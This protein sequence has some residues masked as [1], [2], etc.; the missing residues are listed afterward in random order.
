MI[1]KLGRPLAALFRLWG[2]ALTHDL[3]RWHLSSAVAMGLGAQSQ[4]DAQDCSGSSRAD[5][6]VVTQRLPA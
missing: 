2:Q 3:S 4:T 5:L 1:G 6:C